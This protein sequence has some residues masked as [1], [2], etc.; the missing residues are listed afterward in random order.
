MI[1]ILNFLYYISYA[2]IV[3]YGCAFTFYFDTSQITLN[4]KIVTLIFL[5]VS[6]AITILK[7]MLDKKE[8]KKLQDEEFFDRQEIKSG[9]NSLSSQQRIQEIEKKEKLKTTEDYLRYGIM[10]IDEISRHMKAISLNTSFSQSYI[11]LY[12]EQVE[13][14][15]RFY[16]QNEWENSES[17]IYSSMKNRINRYFNFQGSFN[18]SIR[19][20]KLEL[21]K[22]ERTKLITA[23]RRE[24]TNKQ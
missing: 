19:V 14:I 7:Q 5:G 15:P 3:I 21:L 10:H 22:K 11:M 13:K 8:E 16:N 2:Y 6:V 12:F 23:K 4:F 20:E 24:F 17:E 1:Q 9:V 18:S